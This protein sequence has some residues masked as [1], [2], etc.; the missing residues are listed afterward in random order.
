MKDT[1]QLIEQMHHAGRQRLEQESMPDA[2][3]LLRHCPRWQYAAMLAA[4]AVVVALL[5]IPI[6]NEQHMPEVAHN[7]LPRPVKQQVHETLNQSTI[8][9]IQHSDYAYSETKDRVR[10]Y[11][12]DN[13]NPDEVLARMKQVIKTL[14]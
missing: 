5:F 10:V 6:Q 8:Q 14:Q 3:P 4:A 12:D 13:C 2:K 1:N 11:C 7:K 9:P